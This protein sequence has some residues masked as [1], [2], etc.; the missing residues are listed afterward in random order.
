MWEDMHDRTQEVLH[1]LLYSHHLVYTSWN[2]LLPCTK[3]CHLGG[4]GILLAKHLL[5]GIDPQA[6]W[7]EVATIAAP[8]EKLE[9]SMRFQQWTIHTTIKAIHEDTS[10]CQF[11]S[12]SEALFLTF[13]LESNT[14]TCCS[15]FKKPIAPCLVWLHERNYN[16]VRLFTLKVINTCTANRVI[17]IKFMDFLFTD[18]FIFL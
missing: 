17:I 4:F 1:M 2:Q 3:Q 9:V 11:S 14:L 15:S 13:A 10:L 5:N 18:L 16:N 12:T 7:E 6:F 8:L